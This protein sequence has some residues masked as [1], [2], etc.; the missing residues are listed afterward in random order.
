MDRLKEKLCL[1]ERRAITDTIYQVGSATL[2]GRLPG[3][4]TER[5]VTMSDPIPTTP[6]TP[7]QTKRRLQNLGFKADQVQAVQNLA[8]AMAAQQ[9]RRTIETTQN[10]ISTVVALLSSAVG[11]VAA[12]AWNQ[13]I[14]AWLPTIP[15]FHTNSAVAEAFIYAISATIFAVLVIAILGIINS[16]IK[17]RNLLNTAPPTV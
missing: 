4:T 9:I 5:I 1:D 8:S 13:A 17:G 2:R 11:I 14:S 10:F 16:R 7:E 3:A 15:F 12:L 6:E